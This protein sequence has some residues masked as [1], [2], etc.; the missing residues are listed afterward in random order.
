MGLTHYQLKYMYM[1]NASSWSLQIPN[2]S[3]LN[4][5]SK[6]IFLKPYSIHVNVYFFY[7]FGGIQSHLQFR[8]LFPSS[9]ISVG[10]LPPDL[11]LIILARH[12]EEDYVFSILTG[13][14][15][16]PAG[17]QVQEGLS[18]HPY[19]PG[20]AIGMPQQLFQDSVEYEDG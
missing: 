19:F 18:Y 16:A 10:A 15:D 4:L 20:G 7:Q 12:G 1:Y 13:Y 11:S 17:I 8:F 6:K 3:F 5:L 9:L 14:W 2:L